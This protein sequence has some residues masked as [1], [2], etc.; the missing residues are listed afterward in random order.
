MTKDAAH[1]G[2][3]SPRLTRH[4]RT[5]KIIGALMGENGSERSHYNLTFRVNDELESSS[6]EHEPV[7]LDACTS[8][9][10]IIDERPVIKA[11][12]PNPCP[13]SSHRRQLIGNLTVHSK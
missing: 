1:N 9:G 13:I 3:K 6:G 12:N 8:E 11:S 2:S 5:T 4:G 10:M 7:Q